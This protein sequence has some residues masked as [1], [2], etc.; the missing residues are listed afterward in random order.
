MGVTPEAFVYRWTDAG[1]Q[2]LYVGVHKGA[3]DDGYV[4][5][6]KPMMEEYRQRPGDFTREIIASGTFEDCFILEQAI[7]KADHAHKNP[8]YYN[9]A[10]YC[11]PFYCK[12]PRTPAT[13]AKMSAAQKNRTPELKAKQAAHLRAPETKAKRLAVLRS[14]EIRAKLSA[15]TKN[16]ITPEH[17]AKQLAALRSPETRARLLATLRSPEIRAKISAATKGKP[18]S[19][20]HRVKMSEA[21][22]HRTLT[23]AA[24]ANMSA[25]QKAR[26]AR[27]RAARNGPTLESFFQ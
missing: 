9:Q 19:P 21:A 25:A 15:A 22:K 13:R 18:K 14:P 3:P 17:R 12:G 2:K 20:E 5:S 16:N 4:C 24:H 26:F 27:E 7:L 8:K 23:P 11:G 6:S 10:L 1:R